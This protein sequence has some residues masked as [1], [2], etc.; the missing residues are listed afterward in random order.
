VTF[1]SPVLT[2]GHAQVPGVNAAPQT[3][4]R[5]RV[6]FRA[7]SRLAGPVL[8]YGR[9][10]QLESSFRPCNTDPVVPAR[11][12]RNGIP[13]EATTL[14]DQFR[15]WIAD[16]VMASRD[17]SETYSDRMAEVKLPLLLFAAAADL[18]RP[19]E[20]VAGAFENFGSSDKT[21][22]RAGI[23][24]GF[25]VDFGHDDLLAGRAS[26]AEIYPIVGDWLAARGAS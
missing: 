13:D 19:P 23:G 22:V 14:V 1:G 8:A 10:A 18:Q 5:G 11:Y 17:R 4:W 26:P 16:G 9:S 21:L 6:P 2:P 25:S 15:G 20:A 7:G 3:S 24:E 12:F